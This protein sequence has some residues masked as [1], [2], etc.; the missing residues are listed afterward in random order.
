MMFCVFRVSAAQNKTVTLNTVDI[1]VKNL[2]WELQKQTGMVFFY[3][4]E[5]VE[6]VVVK[7]VK[8]KNEKLED[9]LNKSL[10]NT[11]LTYK[12]R[13]NSYVIKKRKTPRKSEVVLE[14]N[15]IQQH[16]IKV[17]K[18]KVYDDEGSTLPGASIMIKGTEKGYV[19][20]A[21]GEFSITMPEK[22][23][24]LVIS[25]IGFKSKEITI[26]NFKESLE[27]ILEPD[28]GKLDEVVVTGMFKRKAESFT[29][30]AITV[31]SADLAKVSTTNVFQSLKNIDPSLNIMSNMDFGSDPN[32]M[33]EMQLRG[34]T[35]F[36][37][38][39]NAGFRDAYQDN[40][41]MP[42]FILDGFE[43]SIT[44][45]FDLDMERVQSV[46]ILK[47]AAAKA[48]YGSK[49]ANGVIVIET[50][51]PISGEL[52]LSYKGT[53]NVTTPDLTSYNLCNALEKLEVERIAGD[54]ISPS[55]SE[56]VRLENLYNARKKKALEG[57]DTYWLSKPL[58][59]GYSQKHSITVEM[60]EKKAKFIA[61][62]SYTDNVGVMIGSGR[63][64]IGGSFNVRYRYKNLLFRNSFS[65][66]ANKSNNSPYGSFSQY[67]RMNPYYDAYNDDGTIATGDNSTIGEYINPLKDAKLNT[68]LENSYFEFTN[69]F[70]TEWTIS[71]GVKLD[72]RFGIIRKQDDAHTFYPAEHSIFNTYKDEDFFRRGSYSLR[73][74]EFNRVSGA[75]NFSF[76]KSFGS[77]LITANTR[78][79]IEESNTVHVT[80]Y[81]EGFPSDKA[82]D[83]GFALQYKKDGKPIGSDV[84]SREMGLLAAVNYSYADKY[85]TDLTI[86]RNGSSKFGA[87]KR[88][89]NFWSVGLG[90]NVHKESFLK[91]FEPLK[92]FKI[93]G[94]YGT[95]GS[96]NFPTYQA[97]S[98]YKLHIDRIYAG[99]LGSYIIGLA[100]EDLKWQQKRELNYGFDLTL[101][102]VSVKFDRY[103]DYTTDLISSLSLPSSVGFSSMKENIGKIK[104]DGY[105]ITLACKVLKLKDGF[106][107]ITASGVSNNNKIVSLSNAMAKF[108]EDQNALASGVKYGKPVLRFVEGESINTIWAVKSLG[109]D[110]ATGREIFLD[111]D[112]NK[113]YTWEAHNMINA[114]SS[115][116]KY[117]GNLGISGEYKGF[118]MG[119]V[120][121]FIT[122]GQ[123]YNSTL[124]NKV[125][126]INT[127]YNVDKRV[128]DG[129]WKEPGDDADFIRLAP[130]RLPDGTYEYNPKT[131]ATTRFVQDR[132]ELDISS[133]NLYY[134]FDKSLIKRAG[135]SKLKL[136]VN[137][138]DVYKFSSLTIERGT[139]YPFAR[140]VSF[141][142][143][144]TF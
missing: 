139:T 61:N 1:R 8:V 79:N 83:F 107:N 52:R 128:L 93:R 17:L 30:S 29:G 21:N 89:G 113:T 129:R 16:V 99:Q 116:S 65:I 84:K 96:Q 73:N 2:I 12:K 66:N 24:T 92:L 109:I 118:G 80:N 134:K 124:V 137:M 46:T 104:N 59:T 88:W 55:I 119:V 78:F 58:Q 94:S 13:S 43:A 108:N 133:I 76:N 87:N 112:G 142:I 14:G 77:H 36:P 41:N 98:T 50:K 49:A 35:T 6:N 20:N 71:K 126:N 38:E 10:R 27:I 140:T 37:D 102:R 62:L 11:D 5:D 86:R 26:S 42:L 68:K 7:E 15:I 85:L 81:A 143:N 138:N 136:S 22:K 32:R 117:R 105:E 120:A 19:T 91:D 53:L 23:V 60:G 97:I 33:P 39:V 82:V 95:T 9:V 122:G 123:I 47:D 106:I 28:S 141:S 67:A 114:G 110:P 121:R 54:Y 25:F 132:D 144:A 72:A 111:R 51:M 18:G 135:F 69:N 40:P 90:W 101:G 74:G 100:N 44:T 125:E 45:I 75:I 34:T 115:L 64:N 127:A 57:D 3:S 103:E 48:I 131:K 63:K 70:Y 130:V 4:S 31:K 56:T